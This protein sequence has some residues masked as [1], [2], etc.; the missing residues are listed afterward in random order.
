MRH[1][2]KTEYCSSMDAIHFSRDTMD[3]LT[4]RLL[5]QAKNVPQK[6]F[7]G[8]KALIAALAAVLILVTMTGAAVYT[9]W[10]RSM[11]AAY[12]ASEDQRQ[13]AESI[14]A[15]SMLE[16]EKPAAPDQVISAT[17]QG[18]TITAVQTIVD[19]YRAKIIY[20][21][22]GFDISDDDD[23]AI[24]GGIDT[25][26]GKP[27][28]DFYNA[29]SGGF[30][31]GT[32]RDANG[33][34]VYEDGTPIQSRN[35]EFS[36]VILRYKAKDGSMEYIEYIHF[37]EP[38]KHLG[39]EV[40][41]HFRAL[42]VAAEKAVDKET[43]QGSWDLKWTMTGTDKNLTGNPDA[44]IGDTGYILR[45]FQI[46]PLTVRAVMKI[47]GYYEGWDT[48]MDFP[49]GIAGVRMKDVSINHRIYPSEERYDDKIEPRAILEKQAM[50]ILDVDQV[51]SLL[52]HKDWLQDENGNYTIETY[53]EVPVR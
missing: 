38:G 47:D 39:K 20:R 5:E 16:K 14:G 53:Y 28:H 24:W 6:R 17:D 19:P 51:E 41:A 3:E 33:K 34:R 37:T 46:T 42:G 29:L 48:L 18:V 22:E 21:I 40:T 45:G 31:D 15:S 32:T 4:D 7:S 44:P 25:I 26:D 49:T 10:S 23:P 11:N 27:A 50:E 9:R 43:M 35:D 12:L 1:N 2:L 36:S 52:F 30:Y 8:R 13:L